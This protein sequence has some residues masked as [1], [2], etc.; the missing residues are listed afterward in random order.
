MEGRIWATRYLPN[1]HFE[2][3]CLFCVF[4]GQLVG[5]S[6]KH[7]KSSLRRSL[8]CSVPTVSEQRRGCI[9][10]S[11]TEY[12]LSQKNARASFDWLLIHKKIK[13]SEVIFGGQLQLRLKLQPM[14][15]CVW[16]A[17]VWEIEVFKYASVFATMLCHFFIFVYKKLWKG[18]IQGFSPLLRGSAQCCPRDP[19]LRADPKPL[20]APAFPHSATMPVLSLPAQGS[21]R[22]FLCCYF[23]GYLVSFLFV[24]N[25]F[26][27]TASTQHM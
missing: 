19:G 9:L 2:L 3:L 18:W 1:G 20:Q 23:Q 4:Q 5:D 15:A 14:F 27:I 13:S 26:I 22:I 17:L 7:Q 16:H 25:A 21:T 12:R 6:K 24:F 8:G 10:L 11:R